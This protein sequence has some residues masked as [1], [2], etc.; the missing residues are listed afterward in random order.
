MNVMVCCGVMPCSL[1]YG[2]QPF[3]GTYCPHGQSRGW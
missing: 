1:V 3:G 2:C